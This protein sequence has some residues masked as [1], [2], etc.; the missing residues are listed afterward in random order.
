M[1]FKVIQWTTGHVG[2]EAVKGILRHPELEL[3]GCYAWSESKVGQ[4]V[5]TLCGLEP[6]GITASG[7][8]DA[9]LA[10]DAD[11]VCYMPTFPDIDDVE[12]ILA[13][14][15]LNEADLG[16]TPLYPTHDLTRARLLVAGEPP[17]AIRADCSGK[18]AVLLAACVAQGW[19]LDGYLDP[20]HPLQLALR[21]VIGELAQEVPGEP[22]VDGCGAP[23]MRGPLPGP[24]TLPT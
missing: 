15:D 8:I 4:D 19:P 24:S 7:D 6:I 10:M 20:S 17:A 23:A 14:Y 12:R 5:G 9:L 22:T 2:R 13:A 11:C 3:V 18:H 1:S 16:C 21:A